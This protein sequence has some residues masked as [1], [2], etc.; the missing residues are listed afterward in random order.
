[1]AGKTT[2]Q[3]IT[4]IVLRVSAQTLPSFAPSD[5]ELIANRLV[6]LVEEV[7]VGTRPYVTI[8][9]ETYRTFTIWNEILDRVEKEIPIVSGKILVTAQVTREQRKEFFGYGTPTANGDHT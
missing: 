3:L 8:H 1:M 9:A 2:K 4:E 5:I 7:L 6:P